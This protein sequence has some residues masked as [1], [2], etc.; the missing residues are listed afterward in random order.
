MAPEPTPTSLAQAMDP[1]FS[2]KGRPDAS[3]L[4]LFISYSIIQNHGGEMQLGSRPGEGFH[5][6]IRLPVRPTAE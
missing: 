5:V 4:G 1:F 3:G 2:N 6:E